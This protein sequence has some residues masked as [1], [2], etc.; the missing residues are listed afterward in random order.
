VALPE[1]VFQVE[2][3]SNDAADWDDDRPEADPP[4]G[5][6]TEPIDHVPKSLLS[7]LGLTL[8][9]III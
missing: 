1:D 9:L 4:P 6:S 8:V 7:Q 2:D 3:A 5:V